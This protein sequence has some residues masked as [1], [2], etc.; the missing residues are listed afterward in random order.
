MNDSMA[1]AWKEW[2]ELAGQ[3]G[4]KG[5]AGMLMMVLV[6]GIVIPLQTGPSWVTSPV[7]GVA[8]SWVPMFLVMT[9]VSDAFA[10]ERE[11][12]T[13]ETLLATRLSDRGILYG[14]VGAA[15]AY[16]VGLTALCLVV[17]LV[18]LN[19]T[20]PQ[21]GLLLYQARVAGGMALFGVLGAVLVATAGVGISLRA[22]TVRQ[23][24]Q[25]L[26]A[27]VILV[28]VL[29]VAAVRMLPAERL[30]R[31]FGSVP[32]WGVLASLAG[33]TLAITDA[34]LLAYVTRRFRRDLIIA[35]R[36]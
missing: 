21:G 35:G 28:A 20:H 25:T 16:G 17:G 14:K 24:Q 26:S 10:G 6:F 1:V 18:T 7:T 22:P 5:R 12:H 34:A 13:L 33:L 27:L 32:S 31:L 9:V 15:V 23:A 3:R 4:F 2:R 30:A 29:P 8:W 36:A 11:R 19:V